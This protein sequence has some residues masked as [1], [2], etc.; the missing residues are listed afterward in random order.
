MK[1]W[2]S[3]LVPI[4]NFLNTIS[5]VT[6][7]HSQPGKCHSLFFPFQKWL[8]FYQIWPWL[9]VLKSFLIQLE[10][11]WRRLSKTQHELKFNFFQISSACRIE[12]P[13][14]PKNEHPL[15]QEYTNPSLDQIDDKSTKLVNSY[16]KVDMLF[17]IDCKEFTYLPS[18][19][20]KACL[21][22]LPSMLL[23]Q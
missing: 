15:V 5:R 11:K 14:P 3:K 1:V 20:T 17:F 19:S 16:L 13:S 6:L 12:L 18:I 21:L 2:F 22:K 4:L 10:T 7:T 8:N 23:S 9:K